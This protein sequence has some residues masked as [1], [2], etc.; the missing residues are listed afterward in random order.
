[1]EYITLLLIAVQVEVFAIEDLKKSNGS[2]LDAGYP[3]FHGAQAI[4]DV[5]FGD[6][7]PG[8][9]KNS[10]SKWIYYQWI[11]PLK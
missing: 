9:Q 8:D 10:L 4:V 6:Y 5:L 2:I 3:R 11:F 7:N 1:M